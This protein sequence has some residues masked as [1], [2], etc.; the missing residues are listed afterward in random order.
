M[1]QLRLLDRVR[2]AIRLR[3]YSLRTEQAYIGWI[4]RYIYFHDKKHPDSMGEPEITRF[5]SH[6]AT[7]RNVSASTQNQALSAL[8]FLYKEVLEHELAWMDDIVRARRPKRLP[9]ILTKQQ[10]TI[11]FSMMKETNLLIAELMYGTGMRLMECLRLRIKD[12]DFDYKQI[13]VREGKGNKDRVTVLPE[14]LT[15]RLKQQINYAQNL[16]K[17]DLADGFGR[18]YLPFALSRKYP[19]ANRELGWQ[20]V[21]PS[22]NRSRDPYDNEIRRHHLDEK[23]VQRA[24]RNTAKKAQFNKPVSSHTLR[25]CFA[26]HLLESGY[27]IRTIQSLL[28]HKDVKTTMI[29]THVM[30]KGAMGV[31]SPAD[32]L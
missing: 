17:S 5:L 16:H 29:Y 32:N 22:Y 28:G 26:T 12:I 25:H 19:N 27:D 31:R 2:D 23:N 13:L 15:S 18:V 8:L 3:H 10:V 14:S 20:Y 9:V 7:Q 1:Q 30:N 11:L 24:I 21:F 4:K 6:L